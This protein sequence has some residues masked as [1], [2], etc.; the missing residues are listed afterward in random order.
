MVR[1][2][3][4]RISG[5]EPFHQLA[6]CNIGRSDAAI[7]HDRNAQTV[8]VAPKVVTCMFAKPRLHD[9]IIAFVPVEVAFGDDIFP[10]QIIVPEVVKRHEAYLAE[11]RKF[12]PLGAFL[13]FTLP[14]AAR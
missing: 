2:E 4:N 8:H 5:L 9:C 3:G 1:R 10:P 13:A 6:L 12:A 14:C 11:G 7:V